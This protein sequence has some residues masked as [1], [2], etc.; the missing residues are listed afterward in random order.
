MGVGSCGVWEAGLTRAWAAMESVRKDD[1][2]HVG[3]EC[4]N[5][6]GIEVVKVVLKAKYFVS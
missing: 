1:F 3:E 2:L 4:K 6:P 5:R